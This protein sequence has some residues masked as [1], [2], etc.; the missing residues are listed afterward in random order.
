MTCIYLYFFFTLKMSWLRKRLH[1]N[2]CLIWKFL[3]SLGAYGNAT[4]AVTCLELSLPGNLFLLSLAYGPLKLT[5]SEVSASADRSSNVVIA[6]KSSRLSLLLCGIR[7]RGKSTFP[8]RGL[9]SALYAVPR[10]TYASARGAGKY[11]DNWAHV[12]WGNSVDRIAHILWCTM[13]NNGLA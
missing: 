3:F 8:W 1:W 11:V 12:F 6:F 2:C 4:A 9:T 10:T 5:L 7:R 13:P